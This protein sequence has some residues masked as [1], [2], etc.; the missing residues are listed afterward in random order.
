MALAGCQSAPRTTAR[1]APLSAEQAIAAVDGNA[2]RVTEAL[3]AVGDV[4][5]TFVLPD[6]ERRGYSADGTLFYLPPGNVR[7]DLKKL[8]DRQMLVGANEATYWC[9]NKADDRW[10]CGPVGE[11]MDLPVDFA[12]SPDQLVRS[13]GLSPLSAPGDELRGDRWIASRVLEE[14][15]ELLILEESDEGRA[16][17]TREYWIERSDP[18][19]VSRVIFRNEDG[20]VEFESRLS[21]HVRLPNGAWAPTRLEARWGDRG[22]FMRFSVN[23]WTIEPQVSRDGP[24]FATPAECAGP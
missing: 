20:V 6:G 12:M 5:G 10:V 15:Q 2:A 16:V 8:G 22:A 21:R 24:Q 19:V 11:P 18:R 13:L 7:F 23:R 9:Y 17:V 14:H 4:D 1:L 3:R